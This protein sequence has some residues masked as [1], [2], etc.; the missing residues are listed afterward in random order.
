MICCGGD[1]ARH[2][3][4]VR[5]VEAKMA[6]RRE[7]QYVSDETG[8]PVGV[9]V[10]IELWRQIESERE[11]AYLLKSPAMKSRLLEAKKRKTGI[12]LKDAR[13]KLGI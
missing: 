8:K 1:L 10:P 3:K 6:A 11:T 7:I 12:S 5:K 9:L 4:L 13:S 2:N